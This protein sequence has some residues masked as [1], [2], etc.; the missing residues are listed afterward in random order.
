MRVGFTGHQSRPGIEWPWVREQLG[1]ALDAL[2]SNLVGYSSL[3][4]GA[5]QIFA[6][7]VMSRGGIFNAVIPYAT[8]ESE[9]DDVD[10]KHYRSLLMKSAVVALDLPYKG[11]RAFYEAGRWIVDRSELLMAVWD[12]KPSQ[13][14]GGTADIVAYALQQRRPIVHI[15]ITAGTVTRGGN[16]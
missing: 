1:S 8:Y 2:G 4:V 11:E 16:Q 13:G 5:D 12:G 3:A 10:I 7:E 15:D 6:E 14:F 9:F